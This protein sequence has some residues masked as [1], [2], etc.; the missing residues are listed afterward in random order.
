MNNLITLGRFFFAIGMAVFGI[1]YIWYGRFMGGLPPVPPWAPGGAVGAYLVGAVL[2]A[3]SL[4]IAANK[5]GCLS[6]I[7]L[8]SL[9]LFCV[10]VLHGPHLSAILHDGVE[11]TRAFEPL[12]LGGAAF[13]LAGILPTEGPGSQV[14]GSGTNWMVLLG[15]WLFAFSMVVF[16]IQHFMYATFLATLVPTWMPVHLF[17]IYF[18]G[19]GMIVAGLAI[20]TTILARLASAV[21]GLMFL[22]W[23]VLLH[24]PRS[25]A[26]PRNGDEWSS[27]FV[28]LAMCGGSFVIAGTMSRRSGPASAGSQ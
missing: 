26:Q 3:A 18:T 22:L 16:G 8:G 27:A 4:S 19:A 9:F 10:I 28:A 23:F 2:I 17:W 5:K 1:Q 20:V 7:V 14:R 6:A 12:A 24:L 11:R 25:L 21:L 15:H 13:V